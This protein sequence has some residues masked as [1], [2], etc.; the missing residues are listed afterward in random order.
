[1][2]PSNDEADNRVLREALASALEGVGQDVAEPIAALKRR[3]LVNRRMIRWLAVMGGVLSI[4]IGVLIATV[5]ATTRQAQD[6][7][8]IQERTTNEVLCPL[9]D[10]FEQAGKRPPPPGLTPE[11]E[12]QR[13]MDFAKIAMQSKALGCNGH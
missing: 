11:Q 9:Y 6:I 4:A 10:L 13:Q 8:Q 5:I 7:E 12:R 2:S 1:M 3:G